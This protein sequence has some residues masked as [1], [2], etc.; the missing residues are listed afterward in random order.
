MSKSDL[1]SIHLSEGQSLSTLGN[2]RDLALRDLAED[3][4]FKPVHH[5]DSGPYDLSLTIHDGRLVMDIKGNDG[6]A[7]PS[8]I[9]SIKP[10]SRLVRDYFMM[11]DSYETMR[12]QGTGC[13]LE[14]IDMA[15]RGLHNEGAEL[16]IERLDGK[17]RLDHPT[18]RRFFT[19]ICILHSQ[20]FSQ[21]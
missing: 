6:A 17:I 7:L 16:L 8:L 9:L 2:E 11:I 4:V 18:A 1:K 14:T 3:S 5:E 20:N 12:R 10:Y 15:R 21:F 13:Q 19:L